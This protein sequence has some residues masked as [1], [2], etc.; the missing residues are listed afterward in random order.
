MQCARFIVSGKVQGV[1]FRAAAREQAQRLDISGY[2]KNL[3][4]GTVEV[5]ACGDA[6]NLEALERWLEKGPSAARVDRVSRF[7]EDEKPPQGFRTL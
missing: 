2:A 6:A 3:D 1:F 7:V 5:I 4:D